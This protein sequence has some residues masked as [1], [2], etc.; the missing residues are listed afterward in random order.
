MRLQDLE[1]VEVVEVIL[2]MLV[3]VADKAVKE[4]QE[5][6]FSLVH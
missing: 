3:A 5:G 1:V 2:G 4:E 6:Q